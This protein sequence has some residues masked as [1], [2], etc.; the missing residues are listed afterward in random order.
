MKFNRT[1]NAKRNIAFGLLNKVVTLIFPFVI[2]MVLIRTLGA[3]YLGLGSLFKSILHVLNLTEL[4]FSSAVVYSMY[5]PVADDDKETLCAILNFYRKVYLAV[6][7][8]IAAIGAALIPFLP[9]LIKGSYPSDINIY[10]LYLFYLCGTVLS[11]L[12]FAYKNSLIRAYQRADVISKI[13]T[14]VHFVIYTVQLVIIIHTKNYYLYVSMLIASAVIKNICTQIFS[15]KM[16]PDIICKGSI[17]SKTKR[18]IKVKVT[19]LFITKVCHVTRNTF[20]SIFISAFLGL[21]LTAIYNN[22]Y[23]IMHAVLAIFAIVSPSILSGVGNS[24]ITDSQEKNYSD[25][26]KFNFIYMWLA[27]CC[28]VCLLCLYQPF[29][30]IAFGKDMMFPFPVVI[31]FCVYFYVLKMGDIRA[32]YSDACGLWWENRWRNILEAL[33]NLVL[34]F[35]FGKLWGVYGI[36]S[37]TLISLFFINF[38]WGSTIVYKHYFTKI[39][40]SEYYLLHLLYA[41]ITLVACIISYFVCSAIPLTGILGLA[42]KA[43][44]CLIIPNSLYL[45]CYFKTASFKQAYRYLSRNF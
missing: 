5:K 29:T 26:K 39:K 45:L 25:M 38:L 30:K 27:G 31:L 44:V 8:F 23:Y 10:V 28:T 21:T 37:A 42:T 12:L 11:Y 20:D 3:E 35:I 32:I 16:F 41:S 13:N 9:K 2:R 7:L 33:A 15:K 6:G 4:G 43:L 19:G 40:I 14:A 24:I 17:D 18:E 36:I 34:N 1:K 22:Y